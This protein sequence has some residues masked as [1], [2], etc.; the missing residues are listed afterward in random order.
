MRTP[1]VAIIGL[2][3]SSKSTLFNK[4]LER[5]SALTYPEAGTTRDR[6]YGLTTWNGLPFYLIDTAGIVANPNSDLEK[7]VQKQTAI[8]QEEA[9]LLLLVV[10]GQ[11]PTSNQDLRVASI[12]NQSRKPVVLAVN[13]I[14]ARNAKTETRASEY[15]KLG[16]GDT[17][18]TSAINGAGV[19]DLL[20]AIVGKLKDDFSAQRSALSAEGL[21][22]AFIG[23][24]NVGKSSLINALLKQERVLVHEKAGTTRSTVEIPFDHNGQK[25]L[26]LDTAG[27][28]KKWDQDHDVEAAAAFQS[29]KTIS[30]ADV[31]FFTVDA[32]QELTVQDQAVAEQILEAQKSCVIVLN[33]IDLLDKKQQ[34]EILDVLP[35]YLPQ[36]WYLPVLFTSA[37]T[38]QGLDLLLKFAQDAFESGSREVNPDELDAFLQKII[39]ENMPGKM[40]DQRAPKIYNIKQL[41]TTP[42]VFKVTVNFPAAIATAWKRWFEK[43]FRL[44]FGLEGTP[45]VIKY[46][47][48][49]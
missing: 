29:I 14:D 19:G 13:K 40:D 48:R 24:P 18:L 23:K 21:T 28:K 34:D 35:N 31:I 7:N 8:A 22:I 20:D 2:P 10:D 30:R 43:Q 6:A 32:N 45:I 3:N 4:I 16:L 26:L 44:K 11:T 5:R 36:M 15:L 37:K 38:G 46:I 47:K 12:I 1:L 41:G 17:Y 33:K 25:F 39:T 9:D 49:I 42:P 27:I